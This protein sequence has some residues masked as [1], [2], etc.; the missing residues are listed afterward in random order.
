LRI[1]TSLAVFARLSDDVEFDKQWFWQVLYFNFPVD[2][3]TFIRGVRRFPPAS[4]LTFDCNSTTSTFATYADIYTPQYPLLQ[5][6]EA[7]QLA[8]SVF[9]DRVASNYRGSQDV[10]CALTDGWDGR[11]MLALA[12]DTA[13]VTAYTYG[14]VG[15]DDLEDAAATAKSV[16]ARHQLGAS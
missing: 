2:D 4:V 5:G 13:A 6:R 14:G 1:S 7:L 16:G 8:T 11:T 9:K 10:A 12:P 15:S 3:A